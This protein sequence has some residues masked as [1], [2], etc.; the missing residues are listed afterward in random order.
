MTVAPWSGS[1]W[2]V[3]RLGGSLNGWQ[4]GGGG[5]GSSSRW[6]DDQNR[7]K[8]PEYFIWN[9]MLGYFQ[10]TGTS[11]S[12]SPTSSTRSTTSAATRTTRIAFCR[13]S[14]SRGC[15][16]CDTDSTD[17]SARRRA[18]SAKG[19]TAM[20]L[21]IKQV[22]TA[23]QAA[24]AR[25][26]CE[27]E[28]WVD[29]N[30]TSGHQSARAK[31][32]EQLPEDL[33]LAQELGRTILAALE[34]SPLFMSAALPKQVFPP[35]FNRY[36]SGMT[37]GNHVDS[38]IRV[39]AAS[40]TR[41][42]TDLS[43]TLFLT[44]PD[45]YDGGELLVEDTYGVHSSKLPAGDL[46]LY[47]ASSLHRVTPVTRGARVSSFFWIQSMVRR[48]RS[49]LA[50][51]RPRHGD[52]P[53]YTR[54]AGTPV[55]GIA[56]RLLSQPAADVGRALSS[57][58]SGYITDVEY[59]GDFY[60]DLAP[61]RL[62]YIAAINGYA[63]PRSSA[64]SPTA[65][66]AAAR[67]SPAS[68]WPRRTLRRVPC[69]RLQSRAHRRGRGVAYGERHCQCPLSRPQLRRNARLPTCQPSTSSICMGSGAGSPSRSAARSWSSFDGACVPAGW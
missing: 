6:I 11:S 61:A 39:H 65:S 18:R 30:V 12:T 32:N 2:T 17:R 27:R 44:P 9:A 10:P 63:P 36:T 26:R 68:S 53:P 42:R 24:A 8:V 40:R 1:V 62:S 5:F 67:A 33:P 59:T 58:D 60:A 22:L 52:R 50:A 7:G 35:L 48:R 4:V 38:A 69:V 37:F 31:Y 54:H 46:V 3:Y 64:R 57:S 43:A 34:R 45:D 19:S 55:A 66:S 28:R 23:E 51:V 56:H 49:P 29:G 13:G 21:H 15:S 47:P 25:A 16:R 41:M 20:L 14:Q